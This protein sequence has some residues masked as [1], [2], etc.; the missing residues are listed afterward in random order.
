MV[1]RG[2]HLRDNRPAVARQAQA[3]RFEVAAEGLDRFGLGSESANHGVSLLQTVSITT[4]DTVCACLHCVKV[5]NRTFLAQ[6]RQDAKAE[7]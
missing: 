1:V 5:K 6:E 7:C 2:K 4:N 3:A